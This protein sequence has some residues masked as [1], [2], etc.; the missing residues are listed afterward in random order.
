MENCQK[1]DQ[2]RVR[3]RRQ[4]A[5]IDFLAELVQLL[6]A[7]AAFEEGARVHARRRVAL[8]VHQIAAVLVGL[9]VEEMVEAHVIQGRRRGKAGDVTAQFGRLLV[10]VEHD[11]HRVPAHQ[12]ADAVFHF[13]AARRTFFLVQR[14]AVD[15]RRGRADRHIIARQ[16]RMVDELVDDE[17]GAVGPFL[18]Q[19]GLERLQPFLCLLRIVVGL[20]RC[21]VY[22]LPK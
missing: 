18:F 5:A 2:P 14:N 22:S 1:F 10:G 8:K 20:L 12:R 15:V 17:M 21:H 7:Q 9:A 19:H 13:M 4:A 6:F 11:G 16:T 3:I